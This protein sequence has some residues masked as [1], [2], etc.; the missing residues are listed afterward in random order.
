MWLVA[1]VLDSTVI[2]CLF[3]HSLSF[4]NKLTLLCRIH[5]NSLLLIYISILTPECLKI[6]EVI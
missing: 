1:I 4:F 5:P 2:V 6:P 3:N